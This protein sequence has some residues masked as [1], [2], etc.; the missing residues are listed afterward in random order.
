MRTDGNAS[1]HAPRGHDGDVASLLSRRPLRPRC[2]DESTVEAPSPYMPPHM[3]F[4][5]GHVIDSGARLA[6]HSWVR[7]PDVGNRQVSRVRVRVRAR[8]WARAGGG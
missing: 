2:G 7:V 6:T 3:A 8:V 1:A 5:A 4:S